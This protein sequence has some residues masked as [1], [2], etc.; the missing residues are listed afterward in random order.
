MKKIIVFFVFA[1][2]ISGGGL[3]LKA[4][5]TVDAPEDNPIDFLG[6]THTKDRKPVILPRV[7]EADKVWTKLIWR[8]IDL[9]QKFNQFFYYPL[10]AEG[11][12]EQNG[13]ESL[14]SII[15]KGI[16]D[17][18][19]RAYTN[20][21]FTK[22]WTPEELIGRFEKSRVDTTW[23]MDEDLG[24]EVPKPIS[25][26]EKLELSDVKKIELKEVWYIDKQYAKQYVRI[27]GFAFTRDV[28]TVD[29]ETGERMYDGP[30][31]LFWVRYDD[32]LAVRQLLVT[33]EVYNSNNDAD[34]RTFDDIFLQRYFES[35]IIK[36]SN[37][38]N[39]GV[40]TYLTGDDALWESE[41]IK[42][43]LMNKEIDMWEY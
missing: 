19:I 36:E 13:L 15:W 3:F 28:Y 31:D 17:G 4:Q 26:Q 43:E 24:Y 30:E 22:E 21:Q 8:R 38:Q 39:R 7:R 42:N 10:G 37:V 40:A 35:Y 29:R 33:K 41:R 27:L 32:D 23:I 6:G 2:C 18:T 25:I 12:E 20:D 5:N 9:T 11:Q 14:I 1:I 34:R 16:K